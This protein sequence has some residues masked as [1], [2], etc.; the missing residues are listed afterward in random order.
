MCGCP[1]LREAEP[2]LMIN[3]CELTITNAADSSM[4]YRNS[5]MTNHTISA[6]NVSDIV[7]PS[8]ARWKAENESHNVLKTK[9]YHLEH[10]FGHGKQN[11]SAFAGDS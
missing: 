2:S 5:F 11:L 3:W 6:K 8:R 1:T 9:G 7:D 4:I 10:N